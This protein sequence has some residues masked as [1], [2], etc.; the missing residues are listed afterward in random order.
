[1]TTRHQYEEWYN[2]QPENKDRQIPP[3]VNHNNQP[4]LDIYAIN[5]VLSSQKHWHLNTLQSPP[6]VHLCVTYANHT[7]VINKNFINDLYD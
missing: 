7:N 2:K 6:S 3:S 1:M 5:S 4:L